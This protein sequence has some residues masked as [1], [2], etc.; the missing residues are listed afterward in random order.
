MLSHRLRRWPNI[1]LTLFQC[2]LSTRSVTRAGP[3]DQ[4]GDVRCAA[5]QGCHNTPIRGGGGCL[6]RDL[7]GCHQSILIHIHQHV[8]L[9][10]QSVSSG[11]GRCQG[12]YSKTISGVSCIYNRLSFMINLYCFLSSQLIIFPNKLPPSFRQKVT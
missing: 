8:N 3:A 5:C 7:R 11:G 2:L 12:L 1:K 10:I 4:T 9:C 6:T